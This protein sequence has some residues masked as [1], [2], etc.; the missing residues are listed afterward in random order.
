VQPSAWHQ[1]TAESF[2]VRN[3]TLCEQR[4]CNDAKD[5]PYHRRHPHR[6]ACTR[7]NYIPFTLRNHNYLRILANPHATHSRSSL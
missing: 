4:N 5:N 2:R 1:R 7:Y 6:I 3:A